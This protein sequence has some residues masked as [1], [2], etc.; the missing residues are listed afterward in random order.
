MAESSSL[1]GQLVAMIFLGRDLAHRA[2]LRT[3]S[4]AAHVA[5]GAFYEGVIPLIDAFVE[6]FQGRYT[7]LI[8][9]PLAENEFEGEISDILE[10]QMSW[11]EDH[12]DKIV[13][14]S[15]SALHNQLDEIVSLYQSTLYKLRFLA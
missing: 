11:I 3:P 1:A 8:D 10:Q 9:I 15:E 6:S 5:L 2:H 12:R 4:Y 13:P 7:E 14:R